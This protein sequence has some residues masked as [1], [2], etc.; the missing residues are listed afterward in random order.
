MRILVGKVKV[1]A[2]DWLI[3]GHVGEETV[4]MLL[5]LEIPARYIRCMDGRHWPHVLVDRIDGE[6]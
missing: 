5:Q 4:H 1:V 2:I 6:A 3:W